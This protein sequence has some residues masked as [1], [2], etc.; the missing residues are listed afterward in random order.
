MVE[1]EFG[2]VADMLRMDKSLPLGALVHAWYA[3]IERLKQTEEWVR[4]QQGFGFDIL[5]QQM[6]A[7][8]TVGSDAFGP[9]M[10]DNADLDLG[11]VVR[12]MSVPPVRRFIGRIH[13]MSPSDA[14][15]LHKTEWA[16]WS[17]QVVNRMAI[18]GTQF[19]ALAPDDYGSMADEDN[20]RLHLSA[21]MIQSAT[22]ITWGS[23]FGSMEAKVALGFILHLLEFLLSPGSLMGTLLTM[24]RE[25]PARFFLNAEDKSS[26]VS[27]VLYHT[28]LSSLHTKVLHA[29]TFRTTYTNMVNHIIVFIKKSYELWLETGIPGAASFL[30]SRS[31]MLHLQE[32]ERHA[33]SLLT[34]LL[35]DDAPQGTAGKDRQKGKTKGS[36]TKGSKS[37]KPSSETK[38]QKPQGAAQGGAAA[39][40]GGARAET[41]VLVYSDNDASCRQAPTQESILVMLGFLRDHCLR[42]DM[43]QEDWM[44]NYRVSGDECRQRLMALKNNLYRTSLREL[45]EN[46]VS[47][48]SI[49]AF[50]AEKD[51][52]R[53]RLFVFHV[54]CNIVRFAQQHCGVAQ[55]PTINAEHAHFLHHLLRWGGT[56]RG[57]EPAPNSIMTVKHRHR[58]VY[59]LVRP[60]HHRKTDDCDALTKSYKDF[61]DDHLPNVLRPFGYQQGERVLDFLR[62]HPVPEGNAREVQNLR[63]RIRQ[64]VG[65]RVD[66]YHRLC[67]HTVQP[68]VFLHAELYDL[69]HAI[70]EALSEL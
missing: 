32:L 44:L 53:R 57:D 30:T 59:L 58:V 15:D 67:T 51:Q 70:A 38:P 42:I 50:V 12:D 35:A 62:D 47:S 34:D 61:Q 49:R 26:V 27:R 63:L 48:L 13:F 56:E 28:F 7:L 43:S 33:S 10:L 69:A 41:T 39:A 1:T 40:A 11:L 8:F 68:F 45:L 5:L 29:K 23:V 18:V 21:L 24:A 55:V 16:T 20:N 9:E 64:M 37:K 6:Q 3:K 22:T 60:N 19:A 46:P 25:H 17:S 14:I 52:E 36:K 4:V 31:C 2:D 66:Y 54:L 65:L